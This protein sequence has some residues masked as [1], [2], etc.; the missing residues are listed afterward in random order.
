MRLG[1]TV[2]SL[3]HCQMRLLR[4]GFLTGGALKTD[5]FLLVLHMLS[6]DMELEGS[7]SFQ[8]FPAV[9]FGTGQQFSLGFFDGGSIGGVV[10]LQNRL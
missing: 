5:S 7:M 1:T 2:N 9:F 3:M 8:K 10:S 4:K 6:G